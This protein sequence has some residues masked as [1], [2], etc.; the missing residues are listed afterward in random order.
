MDVALELDPQLIL[1]NYLGDNFLYTYEG[2]TF[3]Y[4]AIYGPI[5]S[6]AD[7]AP[8]PSTLWHSKLWTNYRITRITNNI[9]HHINEKKAQEKFAAVW[10]PIMYFLASLKEISFDFY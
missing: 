9:T 3:I 4:F 1:L 8:I 5:S 7:M 2:Q 10:L 6:S